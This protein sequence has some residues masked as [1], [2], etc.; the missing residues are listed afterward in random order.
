MLGSIQTDGIHPHVQ[1]LV[2]G[3]VEV[4]LHILLIRC[5]IQTIPGHMLVLHRLGIFPV[6]TIDETIH[7]VPLW[8][9]F[10]RID[11]EEAGSSS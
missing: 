10:G 1:I 5:Q 3:T 7:V 8:I 11:T 6:A 4:I 2:N 9:Q